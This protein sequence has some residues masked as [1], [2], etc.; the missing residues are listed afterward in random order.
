MTCVGCGASA[1]VLN[2]FGECSGCAGPRLARE[3]AADA[4]A[5]SPFVE[6]FPE[7]RDEKHTPT[8]PSYADLPASLNTC[9]LCGEMV[10]C[11]QLI[12]YS[13]RHYVHP[14]CGLKKWGAEFFDKLH[15]WQL[16]NFPYPVAHRAGFSDELMRR[17]KALEKQ[18]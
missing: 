18:K 5:L 4:A 1:V 3:R 17:Y 10:G 7:K 8:P 13:I 16:R 14:A 15:D 2:Q 12:K 11:D 6:S 9:R